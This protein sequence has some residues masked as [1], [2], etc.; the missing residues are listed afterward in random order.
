MPTP[1]GGFLGVTSGKGL[2][3]QFRRIKSDRFN[4]WVQKISW[5]RKWQPTLVFLPGESHRQRSQV[6]Y[7]P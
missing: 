7:S 5:R 3:Y 2:A 1:L 6:S 4:P